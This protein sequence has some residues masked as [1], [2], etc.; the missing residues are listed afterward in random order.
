M[1]TLVAKAADALTVRFGNVEVNARAPTQSVS[2]KNIAAGQVALN[3]IK[4]VLVRPGVTVKL[5]KDVPLYRADP[6]R[7]GFLI[8]TLNGSEQSGKFVG[9]RFKR[10]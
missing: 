10:A 5:G 2:R 7:P 3:R 9:G 1:H 6:A 4:N 8:R